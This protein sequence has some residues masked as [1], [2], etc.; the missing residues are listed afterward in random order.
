MHHLTCST[1][2]HCPLFIESEMVEPTNPEKPFR[3]KEMWLVE[4]GCSITMRQVW[5]KQGNRDIASGIVPKIESYGKALKKWSSTNFGSVRKELKLK[6]KLLAQ[7]KL[8][9]LTTGINFRARCLRNEVND[10]LDK[11]MRMWFQR[12]LALWAIH[13]DINS[14]YFH[15]MA[16]QRYRRNK[17]EGIKNARGQ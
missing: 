5:S 13:G 8:E 9:A 7:A 4:K 11:E 15:S 16:T 6:Q 10:L 3:F 1:L 14:K 12:A 17:I 2:E